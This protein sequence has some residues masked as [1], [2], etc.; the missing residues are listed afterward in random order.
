MKTLVITATTAFFAAIIPG[1][2]LAGCANYTDGSADISPP[3][4]TICFE[5]VCEKTTV[6]FDCANIH[7]SQKGYANGWRVYVDADRKPAVAHVFRSR[8]RP[9]IRPRQNYL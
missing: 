3:K 2:A 5:R 4:A 6:D 7:G 1:P 9:R 8:A